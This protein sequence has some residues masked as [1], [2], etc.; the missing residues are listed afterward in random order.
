MQQPPA[1]SSPESLGKSP[2]PCFLFPVKPTTTLA[3]HTTDDG[4]KFVLQHHDGHH[5]LRI[6]G[7]QLMS[8]TA[9]S[10]EQQMA[11]IACERLPHRPRILIGGLGFGFTLR[12]TLELS[13]PDAHVIVAEL[14]PEIIRWNRELLAEVNGTLLED[15]RVHIHEGDVFDLISRTSGP[16]RFHTIMLDVDN[17]P[18]PL[19]QRGNARLYDRRGLDLV[20]SALHP[21][22]RVVYWSANQDK[23][24]A[25]SLQRAF[26]KCH[27][28]PAKAYPKAR[29]FTH[30]LFV[31]NRG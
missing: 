30:T 23:S 26:P 12:R 24:F 13:P 5:Y 16:D 20:K 10:S 17:S 2:A 29:R 25:R 21:R 19:V 6:D 15:P 8:T 22:G 11:E 28:V 27:S 18:D 3:T 4:S 7:V 9:S 14:L 31:A 1:P